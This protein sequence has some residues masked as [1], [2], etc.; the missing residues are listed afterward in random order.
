MSALY[1]ADFE[2]SIDREYTVEPVRK[3]FSKVKDQGILDQMLYID[4]KTWLPDDLLIKA[5]KMTMANSLELR[6][7]LLDHRVLEFA[8]SLP[9]NYKL[10]GFSLKYILKRALSK[11]VPKAILKRKKA[12]FPVPYDSWMRGDLKDWLSG[13]LLDRETSGR[14]YFRKS[15]VEKLLS[16][17]AGSGRYSKE[18]FSLAVLE[19]WHRQFLGDER[20]STPGLDSP[21]PSLTRA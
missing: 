12:G 20:P 19:L 7:P 2:R 4:T 5:D 9:A 1:S 14:G 3:L 21:E 18:L 11:R 13:I 15:S 10:R 8:A 6:V 16:E 17:N